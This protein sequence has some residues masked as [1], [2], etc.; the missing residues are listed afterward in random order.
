VRIRAVVEHDETSVDR[1]ML[2]GELDIDSVRMAPKAGICF[3]DR[4]MVHFAEAICRRE[5]R[6]SR[7]DDSDLHC[8]LQPEWFSLPRPYSHRLSV[9]AGGKKAAPALLGL[10]GMGAATT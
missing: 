8:L 3:E 1:M 7:T 2:T 6:D 5:A 9:A 10:T 4:D